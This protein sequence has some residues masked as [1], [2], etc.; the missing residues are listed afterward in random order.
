MLTKFVILAC[1][2]SMAVAYSYIPP[3]VEKPAHEEPANYEFNY[4]VH[5]LNTWDIKRQKEKAENGKIHGEYSLVEP[6]GIHRRVVTYTADD[7]HGFI[8]SFKN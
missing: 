8:V 5:E 2:A 3:A 7:E 1:I 4:E 6:D